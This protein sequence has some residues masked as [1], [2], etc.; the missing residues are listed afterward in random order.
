MS[1]SE[2][3]PG[4]GESP[5]GEARPRSSRLWARGGLA[6][7]L[8]V[9]AGLR[10]WGMGYG[11]PHTQARPD[12]DVVV[13]SAYQMFAAGSY[14][15]RFYGYPSVPFYAVRAA[16]SAYYRLGEATGRY[17][18]PFDFLFDI[19]VQ[20]P[21]LH[22]RIARGMSIV[23]A[24]ATVCAAYGLGSLGYEDWRVGL[25]AAFGLAVCYIHVLFSRFASVDVAMTLLVAA[26]L[27]FAA[28]AAT[29]QRWLDYLLAG[30]FSG[31][32]ASS[33]YNA[34]VVALSIAVPSLQRAFST[35]RGA[36]RRDTL[37]KL[38]AAGAASMTAFA[39]AS[40]YIFFHLD[41]VVGAFDKLGGI[42]YGEGDAPGWVVH[43]STTLPIGFGWPLYVASLAGV[44]HGLW[45]RR[46]ADVALLSFVLP[47]FALVG[48]ARI[49]WPRYVLPLVPVLIV[50]A[51]E[52]LV[53]LTARRRPVVLIVAGTL[54]LLPSATRSVAF[55]RVAQRDDTRVL[56]AG[57]VAENLPKRSR[58]GVCSG[59]GAPQINAD[60]R[61]PPAFEPVELRCELED[62]LAS[63]V[64]YLITNSHP[65]HRRASN[66]SPRARA[67]LGENAERLVA[68]DPFRKRSDIVP[69]FFPRDIFYIPYDGIRAVERGGPM[70]TIWKLARNADPE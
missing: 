4:P 22:Y 18:Q 44:G 45:K 46:P 65:Y 13:E 8:L 42:L 59:Y 51:A 36:D 69:Y 68:L 31:L 37:G 15:P 3:S 60:R 7:A 63:G 26:T 52:I 64:P 70:V 39:L 54:L 25:L 24:L 1:M 38:A 5:V 67:W 41:D 55:D 23:L 56:A 57:W 58:I 16:L 35:R 14:D 50:L 19:A 62:I 2:R 10:I 47:Y 28:R 17:D 21:G 27:V 66:L 49:V 48:P 33:K 20:R 12:E 30:A 6:T 43:L 34:G 29:R 32:A 11:L 61:R 9:A 40:P 53:L